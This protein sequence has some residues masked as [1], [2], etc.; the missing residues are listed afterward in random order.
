MYGK[1]KCRYCISLFL[2]YPVSYGRHHDTSIPRQLF[3]GWGSRTPLSTVPS[4]TSGTALRQP[5]APKNTS[6]SRTADTMTPRHHLAR[7]D[8]GISQPK[9]DTPTTDNRQ[10][11]TDNPSPPIWTFHEI[12][13]N[14]PHK[15]LKISVEKRTLYN[16]ILLSNPW[17]TKHC[18]YLW[19]TTIKQGFKSRTLWK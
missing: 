19:Q 4:S 18:I 2:F 16:R 6:M 12:W 13:R 17:R 8:I 15:A 9:T 5:Q 3:S 1:G 10:P 14:K 11:T 7:E